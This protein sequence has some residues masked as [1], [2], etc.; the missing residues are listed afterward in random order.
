MRGRTKWFAGA[1]VLILVAIAVVALWPSAPEPELP[2]DIPVYVPEDMPQLERETFFIESDGLK[3][4][5]EL[6][7]PAG[8][9][10]AKP[11]V[12]FL[13]G[14]GQSHFNDY[15]SGFLESYV[16]GVFLPHDMAVLYFNKRGVGQSEGDS[17]RNDFQGRAD[18]AYAAVQALQQHPGIDPERIGVIGHSQ[19]GWITSLV[20]SQHD[21]VAF[22]I[23]LAGPATTVEEQIEQSYRNALRCDGLEGEQLARK[24]NGH[25]WQIRLGASAGRVIRAGEIGFIAGILDYDPRAAL[26]S[27]RAP[28]L[29][30]FG[31]T[32]PTVP[33]AE[34]LARLDEIFPAGAPANLSVA[35]IPEANHGFRLTETGCETWPAYLALPVAQELVDLL[36]GWLQEQGFAEPGPA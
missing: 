32:D 20:A 36:G 27:V 10:A 19:G 13:A 29:L 14:S 22:F 21:D 12:I 16:E 24:V 35:A 6:L 18:D 3:L 17:R 25:M 4:E 11:A 23:S 34:N 15:L 2:G 28:G 1:G 33:P 9:R 7:I 30:V 26:Q 5:A 8:G 31:G